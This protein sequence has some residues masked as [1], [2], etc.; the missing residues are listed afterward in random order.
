MMHTHRESAS[1]V[2]AA[3]AGSRAGHLFSKTWAVLPTKCKDARQSHG[4]QK[5]H[6]HAR[7]DHG[8]LSDGRRAYTSADPKRTTRAPTALRS[9]VGEGRRDVWGAQHALRERDEKK[10]VKRAP[11]PD[12]RLRVSVLETATSTRGA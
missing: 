10:E 3:S 9:G 1:E 7:A 6:S 4:L 2:A 12:R 8:E 11:S 5:A